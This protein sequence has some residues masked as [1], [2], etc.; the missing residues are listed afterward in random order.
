MSILRQLTKRIL[1]AF[2]PSRL[3]LTRGPRHAPNK[4]PRLALTFDDG[5]HPLHT[6]RLLD[7]LCAARLKA[8]FFVVGKDAAKYPALIRRIAE[9]GH[10]I[11]NHT[12]SHGD[13]VMTSPRDF[14]GEVHQTDELVRNLT[15]GIPR[16]MRPPKGELNWTK[17]TGLWRQGKTVALWNIDPRDYRMSDTGEAAVWASRYQPGDGDVLLFHDNHPWAIA[18]IERMN[19]RGVFNEYQSV[20]ISELIQQ[21]M[22]E[23]RPVTSVQATASTP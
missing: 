10:E 4:R 18:A 13:P 9:E 6:A 14:L 20:T 23:M 16:S 5:P 8:T 7:V 11:G 22:P 15:G 3:L 2:V 1:T 17:L 19:N 21:E 12:W